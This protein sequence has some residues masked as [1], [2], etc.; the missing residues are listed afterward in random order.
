MVGKDLGDA[1]VNT[2]KRM[3]VIGTRAA[4]LCAAKH[5]LGRGFDVTVFEAGL[6]VGGLWVYEKDNYRMPAADG[7][8]QDASWTTPF[9]ALLDV[10]GKEGL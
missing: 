4:G 6:R 1:N 5:L 10:L 2:T 7:C 9:S 8:V 3:A